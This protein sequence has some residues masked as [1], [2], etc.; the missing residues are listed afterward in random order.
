MV[1]ERGQVFLS[2]VEDKKKVWQG[3]A[4]TAMTKTEGLE[5][6]EDKGLA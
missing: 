3:L 6:L 5:S 1:P 2:R 4:G